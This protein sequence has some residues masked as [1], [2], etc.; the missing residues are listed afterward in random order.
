METPVTDLLWYVLRVTYQRELLS[1]EKLEALNIECFV[2][3]RKVRHRGRLGR[4]VWVDEVQVH[5]IIFVHTDRK[6]LNFLKS[7][8]IPYL[9][10]VMQNDTDGSNHPMVV[11]DKQMRDFIAVAGSD[12][13][14][15]FFLNPVDIDLSKG[16]KVRIIGGELEGSEGVFIKVKNKSERCFVVKIEGISIVAIKDVPTMLVEKL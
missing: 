10:Y 2:P 6:T 5:N 4:F 14:R 12:R 3:T 9:R 11:P 8:E 15:V 16:D 1:K 13:D 7:G